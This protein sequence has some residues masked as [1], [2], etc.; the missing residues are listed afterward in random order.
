M[1][2]LDNQE[3][4]TLV[5]SEMT[6]NKGIPIKVIPFILSKKKTILRKT[7]FFLVGFTFYLWYS[8]H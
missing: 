7:F 8:S 2:T 3:T 1:D 4:P 6:E 5:K